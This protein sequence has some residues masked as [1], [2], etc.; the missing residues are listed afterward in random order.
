MSI[1]PP[2]PSPCTG[3]SVALKG[4]GHHPPSLFVCLYPLMKALDYG[5]A[6][7]A[8]RR[9]ELCRAHVIKR[10]C[11]PSDCLPSRRW[12]EEGGER[13]RE[14]ER[15]LLLLPPPPPSSV[16]CVS[17]SGPRTVA[18]MFFELTAALIRRLQN[19]RRWLMPI[20]SLR[21]LLQG[22]GSEG[23]KS[24]PCGTLF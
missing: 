22:V 24:P 19:R 15:R 13:E 16:L 17:C 9:G 12:G 20:C 23:R 8:W 6:R 4:C 11:H 5:G 1:P 7:E 21:S 2:L 18:G 14:R 3:A 10:I